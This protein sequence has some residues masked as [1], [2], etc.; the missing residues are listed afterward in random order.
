[1]NTIPYPN[2]L[3]ERFYEKTIQK[4]PN[5]VLDGFYYGPF[6]IK[7]KQSRKELN[8]S[9]KLIFI[10]DYWLDGHYFH[11]NRSYFHVADTNILNLI[12]KRYNIFCLP[13]GCLAIAVKHRDEM[14]VMA[15]DG[16]GFDLLFNK[17]AFHRYLELHI[18][19]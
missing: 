2:N 18:N 16:N 12:E 5:I 10:C 7:Y 1:M 3:D 13:L 4:N 9:L 17:K 19:N 6:N 14:H 11:D 15:P 8:N